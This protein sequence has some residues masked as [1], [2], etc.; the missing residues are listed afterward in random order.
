VSLGGG[1]MTAL[2]VTLA[3]LWAVIEAVN[4]LVGGCRFRCFGVILAS[5]NRI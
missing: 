5:V 1:S 4:Q 3:R 2:D